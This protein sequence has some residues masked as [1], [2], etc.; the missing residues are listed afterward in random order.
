MG[1]LGGKD[2]RDFKDL[3]RTPIGSYIRKA[4]DA[5]K[6]SAKDKPPPILEQYPALK[7][8]NPKAWYDWLKFYVEN[9]LG[10]RHPFNYYRSVDRGVYPLVGVTDGVVRLTLAS[11]WGTGTDEAR[12]IGGLMAGEIPDF[13]I[14]LGD[15]YFVGTLAEVNEHFLGVDNPHNDF[16]PCAWPLGAVGSF[17][18]AGNHEMY[19]LGDAFYELLLPSLGLWDPRKIGRAHV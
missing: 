4:I 9:R 16:T 2:L 10:P 18:L 7:L 13:T 1:Q 5:R 15:I 11:D 6:P 17:A 3:P 12:R 14:H 19:G 8:Y